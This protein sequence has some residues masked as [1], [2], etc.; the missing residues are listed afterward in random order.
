MTSDRSSLRC[1]KGA[2]LEPDEPPAVGAGLGLVHRGAEREGV[3]DG[4]ERGFGDGMRIMGDS[5][6]ASPTLRATSY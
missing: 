3:G 4:F 1:L 5:C 6:S 2:A